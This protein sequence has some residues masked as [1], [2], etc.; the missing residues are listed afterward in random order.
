MSTG[1]PVVATRVGGVPEL[2]QEGVSGLLV[3]PESP[4]A[5]AAAIVQVLQD[6]RLRADLAAAALQRAAELDLPAFA[7]RLE[8]TYRAVLAEH[9]R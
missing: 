2:L 4:T 5:L 8:A 3:P 6:P 9:R 1:L 7:A